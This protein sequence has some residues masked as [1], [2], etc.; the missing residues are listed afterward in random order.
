MQDRN[1]DEPHEKMK[2]DLICLVDEF[3]AAHAEKSKILHGLQYEMVGTF[4]ASTS[5][6]AAAVQRFAT[7]LC[8]R[9]AAE[10]DEQAFRAD[11]SLFP[12]I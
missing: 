7:A 6:D 4:G 10:I 11:G 9:Q 5:I 3:G 12:P 8:G 1:R 2:G